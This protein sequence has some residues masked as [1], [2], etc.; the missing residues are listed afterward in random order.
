MW[1]S[2]R[3][4]A[5]TSDLHRVNE[6]RLLEQVA[7][8]EK[9]V[10]RLQARYDATLRVGQQ[11]CVEAS[12][13]KAYSDSWRLQVNTLT[14]QNAALLAKLVPGLAISVPVVQ[15]APTVEPAMDFEDIGDRAAATHTGGPLPTADAEY[16]AD[17]SMVAGH[18]NMFLDPNEQAEP[19]DGMTGTV[20][21]SQPG[22]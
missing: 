2:K 14:N 18:T 4:L 15:H 17:P 21:K 22:V 16:K 5:L 9:E 7:R 1:I 8:L 13:A 6:Q 3:V 12:A 10:D 19:L 20:V 11:A